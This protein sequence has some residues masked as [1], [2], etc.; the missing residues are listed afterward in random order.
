MG[1]NRSDGTVTWPSG[2]PVA[3]ISRDFKGKVTGVTLRGT[4]KVILE[5]FYRDANGQ[6]RSVKYE[7]TK[8]IP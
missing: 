3:G 7:D 4:V 6:D 1:G 5:V 2:L 8:V